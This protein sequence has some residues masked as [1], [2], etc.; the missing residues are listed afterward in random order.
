M[1]TRQV[2]ASYMDILIR[3]P[4]LFLLDE[5]FQSRFA[6]L[7][8]YP[9]TLLPLHKESDFDDVTGESY[10]TLL[11]EAHHSLVDMYN[12]SMFPKLNQN[13]I[14]VIEFNVSTT[15]SNFLDVGLEGCNGSC[16]LLLQIITLF[17]GRTYHYF[18]MP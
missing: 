16:G 7:G 13:A 5:V 2:L 18:C 9:C 6:Y 14:N 3:I 4:A 12:S 15:L 8:I 1:D 10:H 17:T 11:Y